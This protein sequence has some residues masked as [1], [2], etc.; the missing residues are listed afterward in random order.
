MKKLFNFIIIVF[1]ILS[2]TSCRPELED[3]ET[4]FDDSFYHYKMLKI[5]EMPCLLV[6]DYKIFG[7]T[8]DWSKWKG[9]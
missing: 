5:E 4:Y 9:H 1:C 2:I 6:E 3:S 8:C 7:I